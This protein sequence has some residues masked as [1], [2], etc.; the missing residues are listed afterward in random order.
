MSDEYI[1]NW[2]Q[3]VCANINAKKLRTA[4]SSIEGFLEEYPDW[5]LSNALDKE[6]TAYHYMQ[7]YM[8]Q[9]YVDPQRVELHEML[10]QHLNEIARKA[11]VMALEAQSSQYFY[12]QRRRFLR[13][14]GGVGLMNIIKHLETAAMDVSVD[15]LLPERGKLLIS[16]S[17]LYNAEKDL[18]MAG[19][20]NTTFSNDDE[21]AANYLMD[22]KTISASDVTLFVSALTLSLLQCFDKAKLMWLLGIYTRIFSDSVRARIVVGLLLV[23]HRYA[24]KLSD[25]PE[26][27]SRIVLLKEQGSFVRDMEYAYASFLKCLETEKIDNIMKNEIMPGIIKNISSN[28]TV[29]PSMHIDM[30]DLNHLFPHLN[31]ETMEKNI[32]KLTNIGLKG[33]DLHFSTFK[34]MKQFPFFHDIENWFKTFNVDQPAMIG[35]LD[36]SDKDTKAIVDFFV[37]FTFL[38]DNDKYSM[39]LMIPR[40]PKLH[41]NM[42]CQQLNEYASMKKE[43]NS[44]DISEE[45]ATFKTEI[46]NY[47]HN[48]YRFFKVS[49]MKKNFHDVFTDPLITI[50]TK[51]VVELLCPTT[52]LFA[53]GEYL[54]KNAFFS[55]AENLYDVLLS[56]DLEP[57]KRGLAFSNRAF[58]RQMMGRYDQALNDYHQAEFFLSDE[59][60]LKGQIAKCYRQLGQYDKALPYY[61]ELEMKDAENLKT[62]YFKACCLGEVGRIDEALKL[63]FKLEFLKSSVKIWRHIAI[64]SLRS[65]KLEQST[66]YYEKVLQDKPEA[67]DFLH[68]GHL[69]W[70]KGDLQVALEHYRSAYRQ[71]NDE[72]AFFDAFAKDSSI[73]KKSGV[74]ED[75]ISLMLDMIP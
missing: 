9:G 46:D 73:L 51:S 33:G 70:I 27:S 42:I 8:L 32:E 65:G 75:D 30:D 20:T 15:K 68:Y 36:P 14:S 72:Q 61:E 24:D 1:Y 62:I 29:D 57:Y 44:E 22:S 11:Y 67:E 55:F 74:N 17:Q 48:L 64:Y 59:D 50:S 5:N 34:S 18:F 26:V 35:A 56:M 71:Y 47:M 19:W 39:A 45:A 7:E 6:K 16:T 2:Y 25:L 4:I 52:T 66:R 38:C 69:L 43:Q 40:L 60:W 53:F 58:A 10:I 63:F 3:T 21:E 54:R 23:L 13:N 37:S 31:D 49:P 12:E 28:D 41:L